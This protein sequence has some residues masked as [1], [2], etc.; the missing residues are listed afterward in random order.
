MPPSSF[1]VV[2]ALSEFLHY[3][4]KPVID[5]ESTLSLSAAVMER[6]SGG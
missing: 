2:G 6:T 3:E 4:I 1:E 5:L